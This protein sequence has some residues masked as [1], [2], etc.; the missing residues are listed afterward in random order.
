MAEGEKK[1]KE[2][3]DIQ[4]VQKNKKAF[5]NYEI[6]DRF[7]A[8]IVLTGTE[9]KSIREGQCSIQEAYAKVER[10][11][12]WII[13]MDIS[14]YHAGSYMNHQPKR[15]RKLLLRKAEIAKLLG[16]TKIKGL[17]LIPLSLYFK[18]GLAKLSLGVGKGKKL[19]D[20]RE[21]SKKKTADRDVRRAMSR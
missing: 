14:P 10:G 4:P 18:R 16:K 7:E 17:T 6:T 19:W 12:A 13:N 20:K 9:V 1:A 2:P 15:V 5:F 11:E 21:D 8:G 3:G